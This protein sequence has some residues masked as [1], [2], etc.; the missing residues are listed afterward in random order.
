MKKYFKKSAVALG[1]TSFVASSSYA[2]TNS[3][4]IAVAFAQPFTIVQSTK[5]NF[6]TLVSNTAATY[7]I[8]TLDTVT[9][10]AGGARVGGTPKTGDYTITDTGTAGNNIDISISNF[11]ADNGVTPASP[12][13]NWNGQ[14]VV[15]GCT[16]TNVSNA[17]GGKVLNVGMSITVDGTQNNGTTANP[18]F[19]ITV[20]Y[21]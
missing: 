4:S 12:V 20:T 14:G 1:A 5:M 18:A 2:L 15:A 16:L 8:N 17:T 11:V 3:F 6:G 10:T 21:N 13:C 19:D 9:F 7:T